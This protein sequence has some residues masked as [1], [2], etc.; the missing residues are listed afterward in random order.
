MALVVLL[1]VYCKVA[2]VE[3]DDIAAQR[4]SLREIGAAYYLYCISELPQRHAS[5]AANLKHFEVELEQF[6][7]TLDELYHLLGLHFSAVQ[8][9]LQIIYCQQ[10]QQSILEVHDFFYL[11]EGKVEVDSLECLEAGDGLD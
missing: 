6:L 5:V 10:L 1:Y 8:L 7:E 4:S 2:I 3:A 9:D 11:V